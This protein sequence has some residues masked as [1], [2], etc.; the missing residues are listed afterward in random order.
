MEA[1]RREEKGAIDG[2]RL[3]TSVPSE[4]QRTFYHDIDRICG[5]RSTHSATGTRRGA[6]RAGAFST[7]VPTRIS[8]SS[9]ESMSRVG[10]ADLLERVHD[11]DP[12]HLR[13]TANVR[14]V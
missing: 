1:T 14:V 3:A 13:P 10:R 12:S 2:H 9:I 7:Q 4:T 11:A 8:V 6:P 5:A